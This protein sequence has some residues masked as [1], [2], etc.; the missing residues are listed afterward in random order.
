MIRPHLD[1]INFVVDS[2]RKDG[3]SK[4]DHLQEKAI[5]RIEYCIDED[6]RKEV[7]VLQ[8]EFDIESMALRRKRNLVKIIHKTSKDEANLEVVRPKMDLRSKAKVKLKNE[9]KFKCD[10]N[11][12]LWNVE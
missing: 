2:G 11:I 6:A 3:V 5:R 12:F 4:S 10:V 7:D 9:I 8:E 1:Y